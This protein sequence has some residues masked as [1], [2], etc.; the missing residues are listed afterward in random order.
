MSN[1]RFSRT[2]KEVLSYLYTRRQDRNRIFYG[3]IK[4]AMARKFNKIG[5]GVKLSEE[6]RKSTRY[7][8]TNSFRTSFSRCM[9]SLENKKLLSAVPVHIIFE[10]SL[11]EFCNFLVYYGN[12]LNEVELREKIFAEIKCK[13]ELGDMKHPAIFFARVRDFTQVYTKTYKLTESGLQII[14]ERKLD[15]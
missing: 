8:I 1:T 3:E 6:T 15:S 7:W 4:W 2:Q 14:R 5:H 10:L 13:E 11:W 9:I 12:C